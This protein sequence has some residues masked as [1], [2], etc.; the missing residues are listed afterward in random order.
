MTGSSR[1]LSVWSW[2]TRE[3]SLGTDVVFTAAV[4]HR[5][6]VVVLCRRAG[7]TRPKRVQ[8]IGPTGP[9]YTE[10]LAH[11]GQLVWMP[12]DRFADGSHAWYDRAQLTA[13][14]RQRHSTPPA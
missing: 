6:E 7:T 14:Q 11:R 12:L 4:A 8:Q 3:P 1:H 5:E 10:A 9:G 13:V 2:W